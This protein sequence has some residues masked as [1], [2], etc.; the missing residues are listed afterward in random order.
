MIKE[1]DWVVSIVLA[2]TLVGCGGGGGDSGTV[3]S[4]SATAPS[5]QGLWT[6]TTNNNRSVTGLV[7]S[8]GSY[9]VLYAAAGSPNTVAGVVQGNG[10]LSGSTFSSSNG[11]DFNLEGAGVLPVTVTA[12]VATKQSFN[13]T[14]SYGNNVATTFTTTY[15]A[16]YENTPSLSSL[17]GTF[18]GQVALSQG[19]Q[20]ATFTISPAGTVNGSGNGCS[21][22]GSVTPRT[23]GNAYNVRVTFGASPCFFTNQTLSGL[24]YY[25]T[26]TKRLYAAAPNASRS[27]GVLFIGSKP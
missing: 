24:A 16:S 11:R 13:G 7:L 21:F 22:T 4:A 23:D 14:V 1:S 15:D 25:N 2:S 12:T 9:Y 18:S 20:T 3:A 17:A 19:V 8:D 6:G 5:A 26:Q 10:S 27:D